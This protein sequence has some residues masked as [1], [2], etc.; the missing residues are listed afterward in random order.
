MY[1]EKDPAAE[2]KG[3]KK[4]APTRAGLGLGSF[5]MAAMMN[6]VTLSEAKKKKDEKKKK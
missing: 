3:A 1:H 6:M 2:K 4:K 5:P